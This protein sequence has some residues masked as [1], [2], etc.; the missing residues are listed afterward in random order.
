[1]PAAHM[2]APLQGW[3]AGLPEELASF[4]AE[5]PYTIAVSE[6]C[7]ELHVCAAAMGRAKGA[8]LLSQLL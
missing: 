7:R 6:T 5:L 1:M 8:C 2:T 4:L 3:V